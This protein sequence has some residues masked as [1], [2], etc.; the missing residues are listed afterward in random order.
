MSPTPPAAFSPDATP[1]TLADLQDAF[2]AWLEV[3]RAAG[4]CAP[5]T[6]AYYRTHLERFAAE[7]GGALPLAALRAYDLECRKHSWHFVQSVQRLFNWAVEVELLPRS[8]FRRVKRPRTRGRSRVLTER[9]QARLLRAA[10]SAF[11]RF[12]IGMRETLARPQEVR[13]LA[14]EMLDE[15]LGCF[16]L[17]DF[18]GKGRRADGAEVRLIPVSRRLWRLLDRLRARGG[19]AGHVF[20]NSAG[21]AWTRNAVRCC[22][23]RLRRRLGWPNDGEHVVP[24]TFR[25]TAATRATANGVS[26]R[27]LADLLGHTKTAT[28]ARY[29]HLQSEDLLAALDQARRRRRGRAG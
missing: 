23:R 22:M 11:R 16:V 20:R 9:Q 25:H 6:V 17:R 27:R 14:W 12:L 4:R 21:R 10:R 1:R 19:G 29:Q 8:P 7:L 24:Y 26:D 5:R 2:V 18:K 3:E 15:D 28:T 13:E